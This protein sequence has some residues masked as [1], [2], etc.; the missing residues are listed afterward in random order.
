MKDNTIKYCFSW[1][2]GEIAEIHSQRS[3]RQRYEEELKLN[4]QWDTSFLCKYNN[5]DDLFVALES[6]VFL[7][8]DS[9]HIDNMLVVRL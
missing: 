3:F 6:D 7:T 9:I 8:G 5:F 1:N 2:G 4:N